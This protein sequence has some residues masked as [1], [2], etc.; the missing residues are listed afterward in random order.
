MLS[1]KANNIIN[2]IEADLNDSFTK[3]KYS[4]FFISCA[5]DLVP[6]L[7][8][9]HNL[10]I[11]NWYQVYNAKTFDVAS[12][13]INHFINMGFDGDKGEASDE[14]IFVYIYKKEKHTIP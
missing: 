10:L 14:F 9:K 5:N 12:E 11:E 1:P 3:F 2:E 6:V 7:Y 13:V 8:E 4:D